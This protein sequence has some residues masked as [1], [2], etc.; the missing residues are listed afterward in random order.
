M[1]KIRIPYQVPK[2]IQGLILK[3]LQHEFSPIGTLKSNTKDTFILPYLARNLLSRTG[4]S[5]I[6][7]AASYQRPIVMKKLE[8]LH[9]YLQNDKGPTSIPFTHLINLVNKLDLSQA[10]HLQAG[11]DYIIN[12]IKEANDPPSIMNASLT[13]SLIHI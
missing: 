11:N 2:G 7:K 3:E 8:L 1:I 4:L 5:D 9:R 13:L 6:N 10:L 12:L